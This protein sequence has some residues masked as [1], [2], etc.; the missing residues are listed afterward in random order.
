LAIFAISLF[1]K[2]SPILGEDLGEVYFPDD[3]YITES[4]NKFWVKII[5]KYVEILFPKP[6]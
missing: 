3:T 2:S 6:K 1:I 5:D 4:F